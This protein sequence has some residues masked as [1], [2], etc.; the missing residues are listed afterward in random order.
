VLLAREHWPEVIALA[1]GDAG[2]R[3]FLRAHPELVTPVE[4]GDTGSPDDVDTSADLERIEGLAGPA[5][6]GQGHG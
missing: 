4:C 5:G 3:P 6:A 2:A 1:S